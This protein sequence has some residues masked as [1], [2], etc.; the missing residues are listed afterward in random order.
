MSDTLLQIDLA[1]SD[2]SEPLIPIYANPGDAA[3]DLKAAESAS[4][5]PLGRKTIGCGISI[6]IPDGYAG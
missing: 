2:G 4:I 5:E 6:A 1:L 3:V